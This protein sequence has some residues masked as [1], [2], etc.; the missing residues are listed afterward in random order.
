MFQTNT[1]FWDE[2]A[3]QCYRNL[4]KQDSSNALLHNNLAIA[5]VRLGRLNKAVRSF[6][7]AI[8]HQK[9]YAEAYYHLGMLYRQLEKRVEAIRCFNNYHKH[10]KKARKHDPL[11]EDMLSELEHEREQLANL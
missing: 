11:V 9:D 8:K 7:R 10:M 1:R 3:V 4:L 2:L 6:Q 5:Y